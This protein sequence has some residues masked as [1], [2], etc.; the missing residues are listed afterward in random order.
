MTSRHITALARGAAITLLAAATLPAGAAPDAPAPDG[1]WV[2]ESGNLEV[3]LA[4]CGP[5]L[6][7]TVVKVLAN[8]SMSG[9]GAE[10][11]PADARPALGM[12]LL[13]DFKPSGEG[14]WK[15]QIYNRENGKTYS[16]VM[17][18]PVPDQLVIRGYVGLPMFGKTQVWQR[19]VATPTPLE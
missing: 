14:E 2:T 19:A 17:T 5:A 3:Q 12:T 8:R 15:G 9:P 1:I 4:P 13:S 6:C 18:H 11:V 7:G 10:M 16:A